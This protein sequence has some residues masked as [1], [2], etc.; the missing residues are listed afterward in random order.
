MPFHKQLLTC[1]LTFGTLLAIVF[2]L[3]PLSAEYSILTEEIISIPFQEMSIPEKAETVLFPIGATNLRAPLKL[4]APIGNNT[5]SAFS[6]MDISWKGIDIISSVKIE[7]S[8]DNG[9]SWN[10]IANNVPNVRKQVNNYLWNGIPQGIKGNILI[11]LSD[12][13]GRYSDKSGKININ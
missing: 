11:R 2:Q 8:A 7:Y 9:K 5:V 4:V 13:K 1:F 12:S 3:F 6:G 10:T